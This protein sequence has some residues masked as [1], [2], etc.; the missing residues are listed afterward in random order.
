M[1]YKTS[2][3][4]VHTSDVTIAGLIPRN[5]LGIS[6][7]SYSIDAVLRLFPL[8]KQPFTLD[9]R[10]GRSVSPTPIETV[11]PTINCHILSVNSTTK[12]IFQRTQFLSATKNTETGTTFQRLNQSAF[13]TVNQQ[14]LN[15]VTR[16]DNETGN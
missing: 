13:R 9:Q 14:Q 1:K 8:L 4:L 2:L 12:L 15:G 5:S 7:Y 16:G 10:G 3:F 11:H 6:F